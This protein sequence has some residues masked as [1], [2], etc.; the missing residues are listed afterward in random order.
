MSKDALDA[1]AEAKQKGWRVIGEAIAAGLVLDD[2]KMYDADWDMG[3]FLCLLIL[4]FS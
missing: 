1:V 4:F 2:T 3:L